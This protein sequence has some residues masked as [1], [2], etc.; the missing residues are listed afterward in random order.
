MQVAEVKPLP[1]TA[2]KTVTNPA[3]DGKHPQSHRELG[4][5]QNLLVSAA[6]TKRRLA[7]TSKS[8]QHCV[9][10]L[11]P[12]RD[13]YFLPSHLDSEGVKQVEAKAV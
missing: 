10:L 12:R 9:Q 13:V 2:A 4:E 1:K 5:T 11:F 6:E 3:G 7:V 8:K